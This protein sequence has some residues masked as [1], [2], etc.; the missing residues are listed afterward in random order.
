MDSLVEENSAPVRPKV[1]ELR[2]EAER[3]VADARAKLDAEK[4]KLDAYVKA[5]SEGGVGLP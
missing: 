2:A 5:L 1:A 4:A 3:S